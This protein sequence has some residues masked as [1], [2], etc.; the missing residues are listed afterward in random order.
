M[1]KG[2]SC[3]DAERASAL[4]EFM[5]NLGFRADNTWTE[6]DCV[7]RVGWRHESKESQVNYF[8]SSEE[9]T[10]LDVWVDSSLVCD[11]DHLAVVGTYQTVRNAGVFGTS[12]KKRIPCALRWTASDPVA[13]EKAVGGSGEF[14]ADWRDPSAFLGFLAR[15]ADAHK[16]R[17]K[18]EKDQVICD[19]KA[20]LQCAS[21]AVDRRRCNRLLRRRRRALARQR[22]VVFLR[23]A[24]EAKRS[25]V[26]RKR[27]NHFNWLRVF[28]QELP[29]SAIRSF[30]AD[31]FEITVPAECELQLKAKNERILEWRRALDNGAQEIEVSPRD[32]WQCL[33]RLKKGKSNPDGVTAE[34]LLALLEEQSVCLARN[35]QNMFSSLNFLE[36]WFRVMVSLIPKK[37]QHPRG[38]NEFRPISCL[39]TFRKLLRYIWLLKLPHLFWKTLQTAFVPHRQGAE[40]VY[41]IERCTE[42]ARE[43][44]I[45]VFIAQLDLKKAFDRISHDSNAEMLCRKNL[46]PQ[47]VAV[48][49]SWWCCSSLEVRLGHVTSDRCI[50]VD[51]GVP[52][53]APESP[54]VFVMVAD[55]ILGGL[56]PSW[57][58]RN[59]VWT[60]D[61]VS[62]SCLGYALLFS[63]SKASLETMI[64]DCCT[65]FGEAGLEVGLDKTH[66]S[67]S[68][69]MDG[70][71]W[72][73]RGQSIERERKL[74]F[75]GSVIEHGAHSG[76]AVRHRTQKGIFSLLQVETS[77]VQ[78]ESVLER[79]KPFGA[80]TLSSAT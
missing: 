23:E 38:L 67:S 79:V 66:W 34:M 5:L 15:T 17:R 21:T 18:C 62:L 69:A 46:C 9:T 59:L 43:W 65:K 30:S 10:R 33:A 1:T 47:L 14:G 72:T 12:K 80:S 49:C 35:I 52:Q 68:I 19:L 24:C 60:C 31:I 36:T 75:I 51:R 8:F 2:R 27:G 16:T 73:V 28:G 61:A 44:N 11:R 25:P 41:M 48:L 64:E 42:L 7:T 78:S 37:P 56:R 74:E 26:Q 53:R 20:Q 71:T 57:E 32:I 13:W 4:Y 40:A 77:L 45:P 3:A 76:G 58:R 22:R 55:E 50:S 39:T 63:G 29:S 54:L 70:K 6:W